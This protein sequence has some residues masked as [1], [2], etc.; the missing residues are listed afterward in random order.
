[1]KKKFTDYTKLFMLIPAALVLAALI[2]NLAGHGLNL[3][4]DFTGGS[5]LEYAVGEEFNTEDVV[6]I[7]RRHGYTDAQVAKAASGDDG[8]GAMTNLQIRLSLT[9]LSDD[10]K[11]LVKQAAEAEGLTGE[12]ITNLTAAYVSENELDS[13][14]S[15]GYLFSWKKLADSDKLQDAVK[16]ALDE[17]RIPYTVVKAEELDNDAENPETRVIVVLNDQSSAVRSVLEAEMSS[18]YPNFTYVS[19]EHAGAVSSADLVRNALLS[20]AIALALML[21]YIAI[22]FDLN[23]G[24]AAVFGLVH[25]VLMML[26][27]MVLLRNVIQ[28]NSSFIAAMLTIVGY[29]INNT[30]VIFDRIRE[31]NKKPALAGQPRS[32]IVELSVKESL[33]RTI[34]TTL[35]TLVTIVTLYILGVASIR[36]FSLPIIIGILAG[37]YSANLINGYVWAA[38]EDARLARKSQKKAA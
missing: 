23:S 18:R 1:M 9:D 11:K 20:L 14:Y 16:D 31:N 36:E 27:F 7:L 29:S 10:M 13:S 34:N 15:G 37:A 22:R 30:I 21:V 3:G 35:T 28:M 8:T 5:L 19:I 26:S 6:D 2:L 38:L 33:G 17:N 4:I 32:E 24:L 25:D 12:T